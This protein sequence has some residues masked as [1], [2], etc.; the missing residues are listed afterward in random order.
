MKFRIFE[1]GTLAFVLGSFF[2]YSS[3]SSGELLVVEGANA[4]PGTITKEGKENSNGLFSNKDSSLKSSRYLNQDQPF[5]F[6]SSAHTCLLAY[7]IV[8]CVGYNYNGQ[9]GQSSSEAIGTP[10]QLNFPNTSAKPKKVITGYDHTCTLFNDGHVWC[11]GSN[12]FQQLGNGGTVN[13][14][15]P[16][17]VK[18][19]GVVL[20]NVVDIEAGA[21]H[22]CAIQNTGAVYCWGFNT[23]GQLGLNSLANGLDQARSV[24]LVALSMSATCATVASDATQ[25]KCVGY[26]YSTSDS[27]STTIDLGHTVTSITAGSTHFCALLDTAKA[28]CWGTNHNGQLG[29]GSAQITAAY[30]STPV[31]VLQDST[32][33]ELSG[34][35][36]IN[37]AYSSTCL[38]ASG[39]PM[40]FGNNRWYQL[41]ITNGGANVVYPTLVTPFNS[42]TG[43][44]IESMHIGEYTGHAVFDDGSVS[45]VG[46]NN[47]GT[48][49]D[50]S[51]ISSRNVIGDASG[52]IVP[53]ISF[54]DGSSRPSSNPSA[55]PSL[56]PS[57]IPSDLPSLSPSSNP[58]QDPYLLGDENS[59]ITFDNVN[60]GSTN[61]VKGIKITY[62][63]GEVNSS[64]S[65]EVKLGDT[66]GTTLAQF[67][68]VGTDTWVDVSNKTMLIPFD[69]TVQLSG[70]NSL[71]FTTSETTA[72]ILLI[73]Y[74]LIDLS[75]RYTPY[76]TLSA[77]EVSTSS[78]VFASG[79]IIGSFDNGDY[80]TYSPIDFGL[81]TNSIKI[82]YAKETTGGS[83]EIRKGDYQ[84][85]EI[86]GTYSPARTDNWGTFIT[87]EI[88]IKTSY[89]IDQLT[90]RGT[91]LNGGIFQGIMNLKSFQLSPVSAGYI[92]LD[93]TTRKHTASVQAAAAAQTGANLVSIRC[94]AQQNVVSLLPITTN[95]WIGG[96]DA[97]NEGVWV[98]PDGNAMTF[99]NWNTG[100]PNNNAGN[101]VPENCLIINPDGRWNDGSGSYSFGAIFESTF[102]I[103]GLQ[104][105]PYVGCQDTVKIVENGIQTTDTRLRDFLTQTDSAG[106]YLSVPGRATGTPSDFW[107][108]YNLPI[109]AYDDFVL[110][111]KLKVDGSGSAAGLIINDGDSFGFN[112]ASNSNGIF[113]G[114]AF[115]GLGQS[116]YGTHSDNLFY[117]KVERKL[118]TIKF[119][120]NEQEVASFANYNVGISKFTWSPWRANL[121]IYDW[122][123]S[124]PSLLNFYSIQSLEDVEAL[125]PLV[126]RGGGNTAVIDECEG[127]CDSNAHC[128]TGLICHMRD[129]ES[130]PYPPR[131]KGDIA[132]HTHDWCVQAN[133]IK[134]G[135]C[136]GECWIDADCED[137]LICSDDTSTACVGTPTSGWKYCVYTSNVFS[138]FHGQV[139][140]NTCPAGTVKVETIEDCYSAEAIA[141]GFVTSRSDGSQCTG[142]RADRPSGCY[143]NV[144]DNK[145]CFNHAS[146]STVIPSNFATWAASL[147]KKTDFSASGGDYTES[148]GYGIHTF[149]SSG[150]F[151]V[152]SGTRDVEFLIIAGGGSGGIATVNNDCGGGGGGAGGYI[153]SVVGES[154]G[155]GC[156][157]VGKAT[158]TS[159]SYS[160]VVGAGG[161]A[162]VGSNMAGLSGENSSAFGHTA[163]GGGGGSNRDSIAGK[164]GGSGGGGS[165][166]GYNGSGISCQG[167]QGGG[168]QNT[169]S[170]GTYGGGGAGG[171]DSTART[172]VGGPGGAGVTSS[173]TGVAIGRA[174]GGGGG[175]GQS[176]GGAATHGG[177]SGGNSPRGTGSSGTKNTGGGGGGAGGFSDSSTTSGAG[178]SGVHWSGTLSGETINDDDSH[179]IG[180][181]LACDHANQVAS[182][183]W[184]DVT[185]LQGDC[186]G[187]SC[188]I[189]GTDQ[190]GNLSLKETK[191]GNYAFLVSETDAGGNCPVATW[192]IL[193]TQTISPSSTFFDGVHLNNYDST[194]CIGYDGY[195][196]LFMYTCTG[197]VAQKFALTSD[198]LIVWGGLNNMC[199][200][201][202]GLLYPKLRA[203]D[204]SNQN[205]LWTY[206]NSQFKTAGGTKCL[207]LFENSSRL[208]V[209][210]C[211][212]VSSTWYN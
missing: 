137:G 64:G 105:I 111:A 190:G 114:G 73:S 53:Q 174:G 211:A 188:T 179:G 1:K 4:S 186:H 140:V 85:G 106:A 172:A 24:V 84:T 142:N 110:F 180:N 181:D 49:G 58:S 38:V 191:Y 7:D 193:Q 208:N 22:N 154:S 151:T 72:A 78:G 121:K 26:G 173:I 120:I 6:S 103:S 167:Y 101:G 89:G 171:F 46:T 87:V 122:I 29:I 52:A 15:T 75:E 70:V 68:P 47:G 210:G 115:S 212:T 200:L 51:A 39:K 158:V 165:C 13:S 102:E 74:E 50:G 69:N 146:A 79:D 94:S 202:D 27:A 65:V 116:N 19:N 153:S 149:T 141:D 169:P 157:P 61:S 209:A 132:H 86:I 99:F 134:L 185:K 156:S 126:D 144:A 159:G 10:V 104:C 17:Q 138:Y 195:K 198:R 35:T 54:V 118:G 117:F 204:S 100:E 20:A 183:W 92:C 48:F 187:A 45:S 63:N 91:Y 88:P 93:T 124:S 108:I 112:G 194:K 152:N 95:T 148:G 129:V 161:A 182:A 67:T 147:C 57:S 9:L 83:F 119:Y 113:G 81:G 109:G 71:T 130:N 56:S 97:A 5:Q 43:K 192:N 155:G 207:S 107:N 203:C 23:D 2:I 40:C 145:V 76:T 163:I 32:G 170:G 90:F 14:A 98:L 80:F 189:L 196:D 59:H 34:I 205:Q 168:G 41:G 139:M 30:M 18:Q 3:S 143:V 21:Y 127:D 28:K 37:A 36:K 33:A 199:L 60:F 11:N 82:T 128:S 66:S 206:E 131:C 162:V 96:T 62:A 135:L 31:F 133:P 55:L 16:I 184:H 177:G 201:A 77:T 160:I 8:Q 166:V 178:G 176:S 175:G 42:I 136:E 123:V 164:L 25:V 12:G 44:S 150:T 197:G 125:T